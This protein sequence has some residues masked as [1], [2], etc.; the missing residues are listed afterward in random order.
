MIHKFPYASL[1]RQLQQH[2]VY[3]TKDGR[4]RHDDGDPLVFAAN[5]DVIEPYAAFLR[6]NI[7]CPMGAFTYSKSV[8]APEMRI[9]RYGSIASGLT[10]LGFRHPY[11]WASTSAFA[12][13]DHFPM[14]DQAAQACDHTR[15]VLRV[16][17]PVRPRHVDLGH[18]V[19]IGDH[20]QLRKGLS[21]GHDA[22]VAA[23]SVVTKDVPPYA[24]VGGN[25]A[26]LIKFRF[27]DATI[28]RLLASHWWDYHF[29]DF[30]HAPI[31]NPDAFADWITDR[32]ATG[33][34][35]P[36]RPVGLRMR[37][38]ALHATTVAHTDSTA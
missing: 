11:E 27:P 33:R 25:P 15:A 30:S 7:L 16:R 38:L 28:E 8:M 1:Q 17:G 21:I 23:R 35:S 2:R 20:V 29:A 14:F 36:Y 31:D 5:D 6:G 32:A 3:F 19:W 9:G 4:H 26:Q 12:Y 37:D 22:V 34:L 24:I 13:D 10:V 18:D